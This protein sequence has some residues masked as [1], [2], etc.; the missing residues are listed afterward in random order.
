MSA[1]G[2]IENQ[3]NWR[4]LSRIAIRRHPVYFKYV[5]TREQLL[6]KKK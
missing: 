4:I 5:D 3:Q 2:N 6:T 1:R